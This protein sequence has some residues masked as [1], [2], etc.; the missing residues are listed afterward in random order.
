M[1]TQLALVG[2][3]RYPCNGV[4]SGVQLF[5]VVRCIKF[6]REHPT[7]W[8]PCAADRNVERW[9]FRNNVC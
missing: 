6:G 4:R 7:Y 2:Q 9:L 5:S 8:S 3:S 1:T